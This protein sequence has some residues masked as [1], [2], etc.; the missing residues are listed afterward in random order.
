M[1]EAAIYTEP[2]SATFDGKWLTPHPYTCPNLEKW[3][4]T[5]AIDECS[6]DIRPATREEEFLKEIE[7]D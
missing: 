3:H 2:A 5:E 1:S 4:I 6:D 7:Y